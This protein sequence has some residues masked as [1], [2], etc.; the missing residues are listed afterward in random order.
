MTR[1]DDIERVLDRFYAEGPSEMP[2]RLFL[3]VIDRIERV[4]QRRLAPLTRFASMNTNFRLAAAAAIVVAVVGIGAFALSRSSN[5]GSQATPAPTAT[6][7]P[8]AAA[9]LSPMPA[10][11]AYKWIR[12]PQPVAGVTPPLDGS[13]IQFDPAGLLRYNPLGENILFSRVRLSAPD[14][15]VMTLIGAE[16]GC[17]KGDVGSYTFSLGPT[18]KT[19]TFATV[20]DAC[21]VRLSAVAGDWYRTDCPDQNSPCLGDMDPGTHVSAIFNPF[22][23]PAAWV[24]NYGALSYQVPTGWTNNEDC[25]AC[26][27]LTKQGAA[28]NG[29]TIILFSDAAAHSQDATCSNQLEPGVGHTSAALANWLKGLPGLV[30]TAPAPITLGGLSGMTLDL[31]MAPKWTHPCPYSAGVPSVP[32]LIRA[33]HNGF[34]WGLGPTDHQRVM[35]LDTAGGQTLLVEIDAPDQASWD[36]FSVEAMQVVNT[37][38]FKP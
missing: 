28:A 29:P 27:S 26:Y 35:L 31:S 5:V 7:G 1:P 38:Q 25:D 36:S 2:D 18:G 17:Q 8:T 34:E 13:V 33:D 22:V 16:Y 20:A 15:V 14:T 12:P 9:S 11:L 24:R 4:P 3:G 10:A 30:A 23:A 21:S 19:V 32:T 37:F 6:L